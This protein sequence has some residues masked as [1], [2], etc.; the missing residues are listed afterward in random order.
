MDAGQGLAVVV[1][2]H[3][4][5][6]VY[7]TGAQYSEKFDA[8]RDILV[9]FLRGEGIDKIDLLI[10]SHSDIDHSGGLVGL[11]DGI[12]VAKIKT[13]QP[14]LLQE[15]AADIEITKCTASQQWT[16][17]GI[18]FEILHPARYTYYKTT[19]DSS[20]VLKITSRY[21]NS[22]LTGDITK[23]VE[24]QLLQTKDLQADLLIVPHHGSQTSSST[25]FIQAVQPVYA[26]YAA[27][28]LNKYRHPHRSVTKRYTQQN[29]IQY[30]SADTGT[31][32]F[33]FNADNIQ[34][35]LFR[36]KFLTPYFIKPRN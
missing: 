5:T 32:D 22:L 20:C 8:G 33:I 35:E 31:I 13:S 17:G 6:L 26:V 11:L 4:Y 15:Q 14:M 25:K 10:I 28:Y 34:V 2:T 1:R 23:A 12:E 9:P 7:D 19:N 30:N 27:G 24:K 21:G 16:A 36:E 29:V 3:N 18:D